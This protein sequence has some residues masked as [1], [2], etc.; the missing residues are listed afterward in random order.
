VRLSDIWGN[1]AADL[2]ETLL[3]A[4][5]WRERFA[6]LDRAF[7]SRLAPA[8]AW[9]EIAWA[10]K[11]LAKTHGA[12]SVRQLAEKTGYSR[13]FFSE[14]F[15]EAVGTP[16]KPAARVFRFQ[17]ACR[18]I[19]ER[20][21]TLA[22]VA[23]SCG[24]YDQAHLTREWCAFAGCSPKAWIV[25]DLPFLQDYELGGRDNEAHELQSMHPSLV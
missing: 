6:A 21:D 15:R 3:A 16:P 4:R 7:I 13:R 23:I 20:Q 11:V 9:P 12:V 22:D 18:L 1:R 8:S 24:Y 25:R 2:F 10:W 14:R 19:V 5:T 17:R